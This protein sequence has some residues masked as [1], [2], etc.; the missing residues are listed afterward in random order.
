MNKLYKT[1]SFSI[2]HNQIEFV[3]K[4]AKEIKL[5]KSKFVSHIVDN[6][7]AMTNGYSDCCTQKI[8]KECAWTK[9]EC[10]LFQKDAVNCK[11]YSRG[12]I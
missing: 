11:F 3:A 12:Q 1:I 9:N 7:E 4:K 10:R 2:P 8:D 5:S 6:W